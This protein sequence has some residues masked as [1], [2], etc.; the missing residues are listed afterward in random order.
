MK[1]LSAEVA[2]WAAKGVVEDMQD[3]EVASHHHNSRPTAISH[4]KA[5]LE[6]C[7]LK[8]L[9]KAQVLALWQRL[10]D[11]PFVRAANLPSMKKSD[12][13]DAWKVHVQECLEMEGAHQLGKSANAAAA[14]PPGPV[15]PVASLPY[16]SMP[17][18]HP[19]VASPLQHNG[20]PG[21]YGGPYGGGPAP[22]YMGGSP[23][24]DLQRMIQQQRH[25]M[26]QRQQ[27]RQQGPFHSPPH[28]SPA[29]AA[30]SA[31]NS[32][33]PYTNGGV[34]G[35][36]GESRKR[37]T[38]GMH[39]RLDS[40]FGMDADFSG[41]G[42]DL[43]DNEI[44]FDSMMEA[45]GGPPRRSAGGAGRPSNAAAAANPAQGTNTNGDCESLFPVESRIMGQLQQMG[46]TDKKEMI[47]AIRRA[48]EKAG[49]GDAPTSEQVMMDI[50]TAREEG[51]EAKKMDE[52]RKRSEQTNQEESQR[53][54]DKRKQ[55]N[56]QL[57]LDAT[58]EQLRNPTGAENHKLMFPESWL[59]RHEECVN[60]LTGVAN[61]KKYLEAKK[62]LIEILKLE[63][64]CKNWYKAGDLP[65]YYFTFEVGKRLLTAYQAGDAEA[66]CQEM[67][68]ILGE[69]EKGILLWTSDD[70]PP[71]L[72]KAKDEYQDD[73][74]AAGQDTRDDDDEIVVLTKEE[75]QQMQD[76]KP[77]ASSAGLGTAGP[78]I[79]CD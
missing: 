19:P 54:R 69:T 10:K 25:Q 5:K 31:R 34:V 12:K 61:E 3:H 57:V 65:K 41:M 42:M 78:A 30:A 1:G 68:A 63:K 18:R 47:E 79:S 77:A 66:L 62:V 28:A 4:Y 48:V 71:I 11:A 43:P 7:G 17:P 2:L 33:G 40:D 16:A 27:L 53:L 50:V 39:M 73:S 49:D 72:Q 60:L 45:F 52:A 9:K 75:V 26:Q 76:K 46:F 29:A 55:D 51:D 59:M 38:P 58:F 74:Q 67:K 35:S 32:G 70:I 15:P 20:Y 23:I 64:N 36:V 21:F 56:Q 14:T 6:M 13:V 44:F 24:Q 8:P 37:K 22:P